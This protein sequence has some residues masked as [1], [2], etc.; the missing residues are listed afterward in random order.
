[1]SNTISFRNANETHIPLIQQ[2]ISE[3]WPTA[4][5]DILTPAQTAYM[6]EMM[7]S[8]ASLLRQMREGH[9]F[10]IAVANGMPTGFASL[11]KKTADLSKLHKIYVLPGMQGSGIGRQ[12]ISHMAAAAKAEG[13]SILELNVNRNNTAKF[14]YEKLGFLV[15][16]EEDVDIGQGYFMN[17]YVMQLRL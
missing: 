15:V 9:R 17:D 13:C 5:S 8:D 1:M 4:Y 3:I 11:E 6:L 14:F 12:L 7:Y 2:L 10:V 16:R